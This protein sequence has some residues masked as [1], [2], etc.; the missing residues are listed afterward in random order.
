MTR[1]VRLMAATACISSAQ[2]R[3]VSNPVSL[4]REI[5]AAHNFERKRVGAPALVW[6][7][8]LAAYAQQWADTLLSQRRF[9]HRP[10]HVYGENLYEISG[11]PASASEVV[12][13]W[14]DEGRDFN[15]RANACRGMC[16][17]YTQIVW[18]DTRRVGCAV[19]RNSIQ[20]IWV[21]NYDPP[22]NVVGERPY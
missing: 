14:A 19:A 10:N 5:V 12:R 21:C 3:S 2:W 8:R 6:S 7:E 17:H 18:R 20:E 22:G 13:A 11:A 15:Y 1:L 9:H 16:G 4:P